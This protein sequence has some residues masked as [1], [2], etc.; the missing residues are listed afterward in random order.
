MARK[1]PKRPALVIQMLL[2]NL[3]NLVLTSDFMPPSRILEHAPPGTSEPQPLELPGSSF[4]ASR[5]T[6]RYTHILKVTRNWPSGMR[7]QWPTHLPRSTPEDAD[8]VGI[9][10]L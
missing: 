9:C 3:I 8:L 10:T 2:P 5:A 7:R 6:C 1:A 4:F